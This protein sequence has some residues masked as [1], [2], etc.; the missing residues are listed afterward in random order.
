MD[1]K[2]SPLQDPITPSKTCAEIPVL[3]TPHGGALYNP[4]QKDYVARLEVQTLTPGIFATPKKPTDDESSHPPDFVWSPEVQGDHFPTDIDEN[5]TYQVKM[6]QKLDADEENLRLLVASGKSYNGGLLSITDRKNISRLGRSAKNVRGKINKRN[7][8]VASSG[9]GWETAQ[10]NE[11]DLLK[12]DE[13]A[14]KSI[15]KYFSSNLVAPSPD[16]VNHHLG[17][18]KLR[19]SSTCKTDLQSVFS[20]KKPILLKPSQVIDA[21]TQTSISIAAIVD[22][23]AI[24]KKFEE[25]TKCMPGNSTHSQQGI[26]VGE[27]TAAQYGQPY[28]LYPN[29]ACSFCHRKSLSFN[30]S[31]SLYGDSSRNDTIKNVTDSSL[32]T[33]AGQSDFSSIQE[34]FALPFSFISESVC[35]P[36]RPQNSGS[37]ASHTDLTGVFSDIAIDQQTPT[38]NFDEIDRFESH[39]DK[40][41]F[42]SLALVTVSFQAP[43]SLPLVSPLVCGRTSCE[44]ESNPMENVSDPPFTDINFA[45]ESTRDVP[46]KE[47]LDAGQSRKR[48][49]VSPN[50]SPILVRRRRYDDEA[51]FMEDGNETDE[52]DE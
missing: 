44:L 25:T 20:F 47:N 21:Q 28:P 5:P 50:L 36:P 43:S 8:L 11:G 49:M 35:S 37:S 23:D 18:P 13:S 32:D 51:I 15:S 16:F 27:A 46:N 10:E 30:S 39:Q 33:I 40:A 6:Q 2:G 12:V 48:G 42:G 26:K 17:K 7:Y 41:K 9:F 29:S 24:L 14:Q 22:F 38:R 34:E 45:E 52:L 31:C 4:F 1:G 3:R 19:K